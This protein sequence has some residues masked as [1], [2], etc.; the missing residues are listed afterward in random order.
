MAKTILKCERCFSYGLAE[1]CSCGG[2][3]VF[4]HPPKFSPEDKYG[5]Y[6]RMAKE[7]Q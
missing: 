3:R 2:K 1:T 7:Q 5:K 6:R 4:S